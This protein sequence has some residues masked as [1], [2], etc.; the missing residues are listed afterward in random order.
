MVLTPGT[1]V[2]GRICSVDPN[3]ETEMECLN[4]STGK[5]D[6][7]GVLKGGYLIDLPLAYVRSLYYEGGPVLEAL[8][9]LVSFEV[10]I[11]LNG[12]VWINANDDLTTFKI[13][14]CIQQS[15]DWRS[16]EVSDKVS[17]TFRPK[18]IISISK[19]AK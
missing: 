2:Y 11:G 15:V 16:D 8:S 17:K 10:V 4:S 14:Q 3:I 19:W 6:G 5:A 7:Y 12:K 13:A 9:N 1:I 18:I